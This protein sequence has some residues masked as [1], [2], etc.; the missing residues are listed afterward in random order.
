MKL[1]VRIVPEELRFAFA[2]IQARY[3]ERFGEGELVV[4]VALDA[5]MSAGANRVDVADGVA[6]IVAGDRT[7]ALRA[8]GRLMGAA[9][10]DAVES[11]AETPFTTSFGTM[12][13]C[14]RNAVLNVKALKEM[15]FKTALMGLNSMMLYVEDTFPVEG[16]PFFGYLR[17]GYTKA[18]LKEVD[19][20]AAEFGVELYPCIEGLGHMEQFLQWNAAAKYRDT[21]SVLCALS[22]DTYELLDACLASVSECFRSR[23]VNLGMDEAWGL[24]EG[25]FK[26]KF[27]EMPQGEI[28][29]RHL[30]RVRELCAKHGLRPMIW[31]DMYFRI[32]SKTHG[33][34][35]PEWSLDQETIDK[36]P[37]DVQLCYWD[38]YHLDRKEYE[39]YIAFH[40]KLRNEIVFAGGA[41]TWNR[42]WNS[43]RFSEGLADAAIPACRKGGIKEVYITLWGDDGAEC[44]ILTALP[45]LQ[46]AAELVYSE[47]GKLS[48]KLRAAN[49]R[50]SCDLDYADWTAADLVNTNDWFVDGSS[51]PSGAEKSFFWDD[52]ALALMEPQCPEGDEINGF[53]DKLARRLIRASKK[54][55]EG[56]YLAFQG[57]IAKALSLKF[58]LRRALHAAVVAGDRAA[59]AELARTRV[60][61]LKKEVEIAWKLRRERWMAYNHPFGWETLESR[62]A[63]LAGRLGTE[64]E[65]IQAW[66]K[67]DLDELPEYAADLLSLADSNATPQKI[68]TYGHAFLKTPSRIK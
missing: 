5:A 15:I 27:G 46:H 62:F 44:D 14:S 18:M 59:V 1:F 35:D 41:W 47:S 23:R 9:L 57:H 55:P 54:S 66:A 53:Y 16:V 13:D 21:G 37:H 61:P 40:R 29:N 7:G 58:G 49:L 60:L 33:Y 8:M 19:E 28:M 36:I 30:S 25:E 51:D 26:K 56:A 67:G 22:D 31:S 63:G 4:D 34:Y 45:A 32:G 24:G 39:R 68:P 64:L 43:L 48:K 52:P 2:E 50:G 11:F 42:L 3:A 38:Y 65:R 17:G 6:K 20:Y 10:A 12:P